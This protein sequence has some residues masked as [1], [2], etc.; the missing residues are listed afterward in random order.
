MN[1]HADSTLRDVNID[2]YRLTTWDTN[3]RDRLGKYILGYRLASPEDLVIFEA[4]DFSCS[5]L[6]AIDSDE[7]LRAILTFL[8]LKPGDTD[9][10]Y[11]DSYTDVQ[12]DFANS[13]AE[14]LS[15]YAIDADFGYDFADWDNE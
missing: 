5:P 13:D 3:R 1:N 15:I 2:G 6:H 4:E 8:T 11:F 12:M 14:H 7:T 10:D 9:L